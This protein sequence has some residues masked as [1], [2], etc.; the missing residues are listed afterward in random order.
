MTLPAQLAARH[1]R[2]LSPGAVA[3]L[4]VL[5]Q[6]TA[7]LTDRTLAAMIGTTTREVIDLRD[8]LIRHGYWVIASCKSPYGSCLTADPNAVEAYLDTLRSRGVKIFRRRRDL[9]RALQRPAL[10]PAQPGQQLALNLTVG[11]SSAST[12]PVDRSSASIPGDAP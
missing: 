9:R 3:L 10:P 7:P 6:A 8:E 12:P 1:P 5:R 11:R 2:P 4:G